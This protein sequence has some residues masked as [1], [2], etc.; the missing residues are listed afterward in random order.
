MNISYFKYYVQEKLSHPSTF[1]QIIITMQTRTGVYVFLM[2][3][4]VSLS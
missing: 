1:M 2:D 3:I 4:F